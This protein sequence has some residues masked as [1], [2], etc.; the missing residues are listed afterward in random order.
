[1]QRACRL[2]VARPA[3]RPSLV[4]SARMVS[5]PA[6]VESPRFGCH[7]LV[8]SSTSIGVHRPRNT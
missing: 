8:R 1:M 2:I 3:T 5:L 7:E 6:A 4:R